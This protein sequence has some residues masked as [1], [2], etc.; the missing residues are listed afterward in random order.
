LGALAMHEH[1]RVPLRVRV[2]I[3]AACNAACMKRAT[4]HATKRRSGGANATN[5]QTFGDDDEKPLARAAGDP[6]HNPNGQDYMVDFHSTTVRQHGA[7]PVG[8]QAQRRPLVQSSP[9]QSSPVQSSPV[10]SSPV[11]CTHGRRL[12]V[13][14]T[15]YCA[16]TACG[17]ALH[18]IGAQLHVASRRTRADRI[19]AHGARREEEAARAH[20]PGATRATRAR[21]RPCGRAAVQAM[22]RSVS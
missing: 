16:L 5:V 6:E 14:S 10:Q 12:C 11:Q 15:V 9:V 17:G 22:R 7:A 19:A 8:S 3:D 20:L 1:A 13:S 4:V 21:A 2:V 18:C